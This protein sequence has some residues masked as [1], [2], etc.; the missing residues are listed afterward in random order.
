MG[1]D[2]AQ[3]QSPL[4]HCW[5]SD[6][7]VVIV[8]GESAVKK[9]QSYAAAKAGSAMAAWNLVVATMETIDVLEISGV[10]RDG[11]VLVA[12]HAME[13]AGTNK[14]PD[15]M[16]AWIAQRL[17]VQVDREIVQINRAGHTGASGWHRLANQALFDGPVVAG[18]S[19]VLLDDFVGQGGTLSN[20]RGHLLAHGAKVRGFVALTGKSRSA[21]IALSP[22]TLAELRSKHGHI[23]AWWIAELG[24]DFA[25]LTQ[26]EAE[27]LLRVDV[28]TIRDRVAEARQA[29]GG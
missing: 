1:G 11:D 17:Q 25:R 22:A 9:H 16:A 3:V 13:G 26:S 27:Y 12:V 15:A 6:P 21:K 20:L 7:D 5:D 28:D 18:T 4:R 10:V 23:E 8:A 2:N 24:F 29:A 19:Y 14:I